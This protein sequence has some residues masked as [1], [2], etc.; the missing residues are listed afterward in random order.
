MPRILIASV[1]SL[2]GQNILDSLEGRRQDVE[3]V[4]VNSTAAAAGNFRCDRAY[5][6]PPAASAGEYLDRLASIVHEEQP[7]LVLPGRDDDVLALARLKE[8][9]NR[10][11]A[12]F[13]VGTYRLARILDDKWA[14]QQ[15]ADSH[16]LPFVEG[17]L[18]DD[19]P[20]VDRLLARHGYPLIAKPRDGNGSRGI[21]L[22]FDEAQRAS[23]AK[24]PGCL[25]QPYLE[26]EPE[27]LD[28][29]DLTRDGTP[30]FHAPSLQ[31]IACQAIIGP[32]GQVLE[33]I[34]TIVELVM[35]RLEKTYWLDD[36]HVAEVVLRYA[37]TFAREGWVGPL[38]LQ[39]RRDGSGSFRVFELNGR[40]TGGTTARLHLGLDEV[41]LLFAA[42]AGSAL[43]PRRGIGKRGIVTKSLT[44]F[45][46]DP[47]D[48]GRLQS[49]G[50]W[51]RAG[52]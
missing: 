34:C 36:P 21:R 10:P 23:I 19:P 1:G 38:N 45:V 40:C 44:E 16:G 42:F 31:Q 9:N 52:G 2:V 41:G 14:S 48:V 29:R 28:W 24:Q 49:E 35:G 46:T 7:D 4:G 13:P 17:A 6:A 27:I 39:G 18:A 30:L 51:Q 43:P 3:V 11:A 15:F 5:L 12:S 25:F 47:D 37:E 26:P 32:Q 50:R 8:A 22:V 20:A 33:L